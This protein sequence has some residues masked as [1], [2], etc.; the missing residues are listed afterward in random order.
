MSQL[1]S[2]CL[3]CNNLCR[4]YVSL[5]FSVLT[6]LGL[7]RVILRAGLLPSLSSSSVSLLPPPLLK[8]ASFVDADGWAE[9]YLCQSHIGAD[10]FPQVYHLLMQIHSGIHKEVSK[11]GFFR[12]KAGQ[13]PQNLKQGSLLFLSVCILQLLY[14]RLHP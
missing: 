9:H 11:S 12:L 8:R 14:P 3:T 2:H 4:I 10:L 5:P 6:L 13:V 1:S 7:T